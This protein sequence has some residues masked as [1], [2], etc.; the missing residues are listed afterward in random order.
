MPIQV[1][2]EINLLTTDRILYI[3]PSPPFYTFPSFFMFLT[4]LSLKIIMI[5]IIPPSPIPLPLSP[6]IISR[7]LNWTVPNPTE[8]RRDIRRRSLNNFPI[9]VS[10]CMMCVT[11]SVTFGRIQHLRLMF[12]QVYR[13]LVVFT[14]TSSWSTCVNVIISVVE[15]WIKK[16]SISYPPCAKQLFMSHQVT[17]HV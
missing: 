6:Q 1:C 16:I 3:N 11:V 8:L 12:L 5:I 10:E 13:M 7:Y 14:N 4:P 17:D 2:L 15:S 9:M